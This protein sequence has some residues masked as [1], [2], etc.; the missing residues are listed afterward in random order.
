MPPPSLSMTTIRTGVSTSRRAAR[1]PMSCSRPRSPVTIVVGR[2]L[3]RGGADP[4]GD[5]AVDPVG[6]AVA[7][8]AGVGLGRR[9]G[10]PPGRGSACSRPCRR[11]RRRGGRAPSARCSAGLGE[12]RRRRPAR[13][14]SPPRAARSAS[15]Q[16]SAV[17][18][19]AAP[20]ARRPA[21]GELGRVGAQQR[22]RAAARL[23]PAAE[24]VD[25]ELVGAGGREPGA[26]RLAGRHLAEAQDEVGPHALGEAPRRAAAGR[27]RRPRA[28]GRG[29]RSAAARS[30]R[31]G[32]GSRPPRRGGRAARAARGRAGARRRSPR[33]SASSMCLATS[34]SRNSEG[35]WSMPRDRGQRPPRRALRAP[36]GRSP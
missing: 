6:A 35:S 17:L 8:E 1:P 30:A 36:A 5:Q 22:R 24:R 27:R 11:G 10:T 21:R 33:S 7:E 15:I 4:R 25:D 19:V 28:S 26:Q 20:D 3:A 18:A 2:P 12:R 16:A 9:A 34:S 23:V 14:R 31:R 32:S 13:R 29:G